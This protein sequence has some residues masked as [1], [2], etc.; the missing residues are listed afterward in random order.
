MAQEYEIESCV[1][2]Y[3][4]YK[5]IW[6]AQVG[7]LLVCERDQYNVQDRYAVSVKKDGNVIGHLPRKISRVCSV[8]LRR[9]GNIQCIIVAQRRYSSDLPQGGLEVPCSLLFRGED[10]EIKKLKRLL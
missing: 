6:I 1:R 2:G 4:V 9:G 10:K 5:D 7:E 8:F 3:H